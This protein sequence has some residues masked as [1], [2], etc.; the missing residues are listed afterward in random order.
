MPADCQAHQ[1]LVVDDEE[2]L[3]Q[4]TRAVLENAGFRVLTAA[5]GLESLELY[6]KGREDIALVVLD[7]AMPGMSGEEV[8][9][10]LR[11][12]DPNVKVLI[13]SATVNGDALLQAGA[14]AIVKKP[15]RVDQL[16]RSVQ[17]ALAAVSA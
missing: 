15:F 16:L 3:R 6:R 9:R 5:D 11:A 7:L 10:E 8:L 14:Q 17:Q 12:L 4:L 13:S 1:I 2:L